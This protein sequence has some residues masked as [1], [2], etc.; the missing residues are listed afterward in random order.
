MRGPAGRRI[1]CRVSMFERA[2]DPAVLVCQLPPVNLP[3][4]GEQWRDHFD[5]NVRQLRK[6]Q[7]AYDSARFCEVEFSAGELS[8]FTVRCEREF[9]PLRWTGHR[10]KEKY[11]VRLQEDIG[12]GGRLVVFRVPFEQPTMIELLEMSA[13]H[14]VPEAG[15]LTSPNSITSRRP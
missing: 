2:D 4:T 5:R 12:S 15:G 3:L 8:A 10:V 11:V 7:T 13:K 9:T 14:A 1:E 6:A